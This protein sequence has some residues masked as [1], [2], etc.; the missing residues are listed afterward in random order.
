MFTQPY[1]LPDPYATAAPHRLAMLHFKGNKLQNRLL[2]AGRGF[3]PF[4]L[5][6]LLYSQF[7]TD[8]IHFQW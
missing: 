5:I 1:L 8:K 2:L 7:N 3:T 6:L 4:R